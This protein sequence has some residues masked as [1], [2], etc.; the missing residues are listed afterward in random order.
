MATVIDK[1]KGPSSLSLVPKA[2]MDEMLKLDAVSKAAS[3]DLA[4]AERNATTWPKGSLW[5]AP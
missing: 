5:R 4:I 1:P 2:D 3:H